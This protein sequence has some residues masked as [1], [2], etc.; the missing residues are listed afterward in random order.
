MSLYALFCIAMLL[1]V[2]T[3]RTQL[4]ALRG[5]IVDTSGVI[6][7]LIAI[8]SGI[9][10]FAVIAWGFAS[11]HWYIALPIILLGGLIS[12]TI[13]TLKSFAFWYQTRALVDFIAVALTIFLWVWYWPF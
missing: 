9:S 8:T 3:G 1:Q 13:V 5:Y 2:I 4:L 10:F 11:L 12:G 7:S 6:A